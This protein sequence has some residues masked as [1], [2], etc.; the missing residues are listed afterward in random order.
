MGRFGISLLFPVLCFL[1]SCSSKGDDNISLYVVEQKDF[2]NIVTIDGYAEP[3]RFTSLVSPRFIEGTIGFLVEDGTIVKEGDVLCTIEAPSLQSNYDEMVLTLEQVEANLTKTKADLDL[4]YALLEAQVQ[5]NEADSEIARLDSL[6]LQY[7]PKNQR[8]IKELELEK[9]AIER[10]KFE[11][12]L[13]AL[14]IINQSEIRKIELEI[15]QMNNYLE[16]MKAHLESLILKAP[17]DGLVVRSMSMLTDA[18]FIVG[19]MVWGNMAI[20]TMPEMDKMKIIIKAPERDFKSINLN[21]TVCFTF[22]AMPGEVGFGKILK[23]APVAQTLNRDSKVKFFEIEATLDTVSK[24]PEPGFTANCDILVSHLKDTLVI[25]QVSIFEEDSMKVVFVKNDKNFEMRQ[26]Q[27]GLTSAKEAVITAGLKV[28][29]RIAL[30]RPKDSSVKKRTLI[31]VSKE[32][33]Q[34]QSIDTDTL[35]ISGAD[36]FIMEQIQIE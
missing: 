13:Q 6:Q 8:R 29:D 34:E 25:P 24:M 12:K 17:H 35:Q 20:L 9:T 10:A 33:I 4:Q 22:D 15:R 18:K 7:S 21:D 2:N 30:S 1:L 31:P 19:D 14:E 16:E 11:K 3:E 23:K 32:I 5:N 36:K 28:G 27:T 26:V